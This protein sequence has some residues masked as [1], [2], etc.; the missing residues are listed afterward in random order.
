M[1][2]TNKLPHTMI[3]YQE[4]RAVI[5]LEPTSFKS[6]PVPAKSFLA[7]G[8][9]ARERKSAQESERTAG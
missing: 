4:Y 6:N 7:G 9:H 8:G 5:S 3:A 2:G 1:S